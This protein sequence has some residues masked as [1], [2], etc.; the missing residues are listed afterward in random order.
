[1]S[2]RP[3]ERDT[4]VRSSDRAGPAAR[5]FPVGCLRAA[6]TLEDA[7]AVSPRLS[8]V[9][10]EGDASRQSLGAGPKP[11]WRR[12]TAIAAKDYEA[13]WRTREKPR[14][15]R[16]FRPAGGGAAKILAGSVPR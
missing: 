8:K 7:S 11:R 3:I 4:P 5:L 10:E 9:E 1:M 15:W 2:A 16:A 12:R 6:T 13:R 14:R